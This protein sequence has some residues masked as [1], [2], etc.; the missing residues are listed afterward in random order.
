MKYE[1]IISQLIMKVITQ[2]NIDGIA[3]LSKQGKDDFQYPHGVNLAI[4]TSDIS[5][6]MEYSKY[7]NTFQMTKP[8]AIN[9][10]HDCHL[11]EKS[12]I[13]KN[14]IKYSEYETE[15]FTSKVWVNN[16]YVFYDETYF[17]NL[18]IF[19]LTSPFITLMFISIAKC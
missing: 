11:V 6:N 8:F 17:Q 14:F 2:F 4:P 19:W 3:Y 10:K 1:Y 13:N 12:Y 15:N 16:E 18:M 5:R 7:C 9:G